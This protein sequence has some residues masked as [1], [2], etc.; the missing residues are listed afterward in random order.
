M[1]SLPTGSIVEVTPPGTRGQPRRFIISNDTLLRIVLLNL[2]LTAAIFAAPP[3]AAPQVLWY[4]QPAVKWE[5]ALPLGNG[6]LG[7]MVFG[8]VQ[9]ERIQLNEDTIWNGRKR[10]RVNPGAAQALPE[11][12]RLLFEGKPLE[13]TKLADEKLMGVPNRQP[14]YQ[15][16]GDLILTFPDLEN[17]ADYRRELNLETGI[18]KVA[19]RAGDAHC[20]REVF[21]SAPAQAVV[22][23]VSCDQPQRVS[24]RVALTR[25]QDGRTEAAPPDGLI[26]TGEAIAHTNAWITP[27]LSAERLAAERAQLEP[28][29]VKFRAVLRA[30]A[31]GGSVAASGSELIVSNAN[32]AT[33]IL[34]AATDY[35]GGDP[36][37]ACARYLSRAVKP[38]DALRS[39]HVADHQ[40]LF[41]RVELDLGST[42]A[43]AAALP[44][45]DR[46]A[47]FRNGAADPGLAALYFQFGRYL[48][49][50]S[51][52][53]GSMAANLQGIWNDK[54]APPW[55][56]KYTININT[57]MNYWPAE[58]ANLAETTGPLFDLVK[59]SIPSGRRTARE[60]YGC[61]G[62]CFH[63]NLDAWG[64]TAPVDYAYCGTW[65]M[66]GAWLA[67]HF[68]EHYRFGLDR[69]FL[70][71]EAY[72]VMKE[73]A[74]F[75]ADFLIED[76]KGRLVTNPS[77][78]PEN[79]YRMADGTVAH[80]TVG[81]TMDYEI[82]HVLFTAC[83]QA[84]QTLG[85]DAPFR[86]RLAATLKRIPELKKGKYGQLQE[87]SEDYDEPNPGMGHVSHMFAVY[88]GDEITLH[89]T[90]EWAQA[91]QVSLQRR[92]DHG[93]GR[94]GWPA[95]WYANIWARLGDGDQAFDGIRNLL[96]RSATAS[97][98]NGGRVYQIDGNLGGAAGVAEML[99]QSHEGEI[100][101]LPALPAAWPQGRFKG[102]RA[103]GAI[104]VDAEWSGGRATSA[105][106]RPAVSGDQRLR[107]PRG[108][109][110]SG[111]RCQGRDVAVKAEAGGTF[112]VRLDARQEYVVAF[113]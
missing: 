57:E 92:V 100:A 106:L 108:Q 95:A 35:A 42:D 2:P 72:P 110:I 19:Y 60:M 111:I 87:W 80:L 85:V 71:R 78:S 102:L 58:V 41:H 29:G 40:S 73:A 68:W 64:D 7:A 48:L 17:A 66:G 10:D 31:E 109:R 99:L 61:G 94:G 20:T 43:D 21:V 65:P 9:R 36:A 6:R 4:R 54:M 46:L 22:V 113:E 89:G 107:P 3:A 16:L 33:L 27:N 55:D 28:G 103:R 82:I 97:L 34:V 11:V 63:H 52:R 24:L 86:E 90:P 51:S 12:R 14:P 47:R 67:L 69:G 76:G 5:D 15:P 77:Y 96:A 75:L 38:F 104:E 83:I 98:L 50:A 49:M 84:A 23:H 62:F 26:L 93:G 39:A 1:P 74:E 59:M 88:P 18:A 37:A 112:R 32:A 101:I 91:A 56:S 79:S 30:V 25:E 45:D 70:A 8:G 44:T 13:A 53:P 81:A 105:R